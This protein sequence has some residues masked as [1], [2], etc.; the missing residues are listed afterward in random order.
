M[1]LIHRKEYISVFLGAGPMCLR[2][3]DQENTSTC[4][5]VDCVSYWVLRAVREKCVLTVVCSVAGE[6]TVGGGWCG[7]TWAR[8]RVVCCHRNV[9]K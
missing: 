6:W 3:L 7:E 5:N 4:N 9:S 8:F 2:F 1:L